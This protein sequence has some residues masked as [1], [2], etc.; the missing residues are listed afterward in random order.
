MSTSEHI[1][2]VTGSAGGIGG[3]VRDVLSTCAY[4]VVGLD[5][6]KSERDAGAFIECD[7]ADEPSVDLAVREVITRYGRIDALVNC[8]GVLSSSTALEETLEEW[9][10]VLRINLTGT[11][12]VARSVLRRMVTSGGG[13]I[14][15]I[16]S[17]SAV[18]SSMFSSLSYGA[19]KAGVVAMSRTMAA[20]FAQ[21]NV[22]VNCVAPGVVDTPMLKDLT[23]DQRS[24]AMARSPLNRLVDTVAVAHAV[25]YLLSAEAGD[26]TG[27]TLHVNAGAYMS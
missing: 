21:Y 7:V 14:V 25:R 8:A 17:I 19:S 4:T 6:N 24:A 11:F 2:I 3:R 27:E 10:R 22:R 20:Q 12:L 1:C 9:E 26:V 23:V 18:Q 15:N 16:A 5:V 13:S